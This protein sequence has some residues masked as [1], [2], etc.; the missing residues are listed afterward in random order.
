M[1]GFFLFA[2]AARPALGPMHHPIQWIMGDFPRGK[3]DVKL[4]TYLHLIP[5]SRKRGATFPLPQRVF[6][7]RYLVKHRDNFTF[8]EKNTYD[9]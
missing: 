2:S 9:K 4:T 6:M 8:M 3:A 1:K 7:A 5:K